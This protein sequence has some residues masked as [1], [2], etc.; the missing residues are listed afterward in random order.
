MSEINN[1][2]Q[3][4]IFILGSARSGT[5]I[6]FEAITSGLEAPGYR[7]GHFLP[8]IGMVIKQVEQYYSAKTRLMSNDKLMIAHTS[9][10]EIE[11]QIL[12][13]FRNTCRSLFSE[14]VWIEKTPDSLMIEASPYLLRTWPKSRFIFAKRRG[15]EC[16]AS[17]LRKFPTHV[18][19]ETHCKIWKQCMEGWL[20]VIEYLGGHYIEIDQREIALN[21][22]LVANKLGL[23]LQLSPEKINKIEHIFSTKRLQ[24]TGGSENPKATNITEIGWTNQEIEIFRKHCG[25]VSKQFSYSESS[26]YYLNNETS[27]YPRRIS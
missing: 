25:D 9:Q 19:F 17:R 7:E 11:Q 13:V 5:S 27:Y 23:F 22:K 15:L 1:L 20:K 6:L 8:L 12:E 24:N 3:E 10:S 4:P 14:Q 16:I 18:S 26:S 21:P 2:E